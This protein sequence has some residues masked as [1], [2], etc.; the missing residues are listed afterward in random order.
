MS[1]WEVAY[2]AP[3][4]TC[5]ETS[6]N[7]QSLE[8]GLVDLSITSLSKSLSSEKRTF[9][10]NIWE[11]FQKVVMQ[12]GSQVR[13][14]WCKQSAGFFLFFFFFWSFVDLE[15]CVNFRCKAKLISDPYTYIH[16]FF[17][18]LFLDYFIIYF[19]LDLYLFYRLF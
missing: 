18:G 10:V 2:F 9:Q 15:C 7:F 11:S 5:S 16:S 8:A 19:I 6:K 3:L 1:H 4:Q 13:P 17:F 14:V 12:I